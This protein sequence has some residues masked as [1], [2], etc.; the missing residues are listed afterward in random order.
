MPSLFRPLCRRK[1]TA[2]VTT[3]LF[4][5]IVL[6][7]MGCAV[8]NRATSIDGNYG[9]V[10]RVIDGDTLLMENGERVRLIG[11]DSPETK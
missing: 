8:P 9:I 5:N 10:E 11:V 3:V 6:S 7:L 2:T 4:L 1:L